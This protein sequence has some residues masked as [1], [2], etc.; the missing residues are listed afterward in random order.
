MIHLAKEVLPKKN[1]TDLWA[2]R[3]SIYILRDTSKND[4]LKALTNQPQKRRKS[5]S[6]GELS[7]G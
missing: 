4:K 5:F 1:P 2:I 7:K 6:G 3:I